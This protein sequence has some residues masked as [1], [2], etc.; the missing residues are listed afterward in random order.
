MQTSTSLLL[1][2][3]LV[4]CVICDTLT[5]VSTIPVR[6]NS[7]T[8]FID[9]SVWYRSN[10]NTLINGNNELAIPAELQPQEF[11]I[12]N[13]TSVAVLFANNA[14]SVPFY[15]TD[16]K[17]EMEKFDQLKDYQDFR[18]IDMRYLDT[19]GKEYIVA[20]IYNTGATVY[21]LIA[22]CL[23][24]KEKVE[25]L[26]NGR[27]PAVRIYQG[28][29]YYLH[30]NYTTGT[31]GYLFKYDPSTGEQSLLQQW[32]YFVS[33]MFLVND[34]IFYHTEEKVL[35]R[36]SITHGT[37]SKTTLDQNA[38]I[39]KAVP[40]GSLT[41]QFLISTN[42]PNTY[43]CPDTLDA[44]KTYSFGAY[45][46][47]A[48]QELWWTVYIPKYTEDKLMTL[49]NKNGEL[50]TLI[51]VLHMN[52][53]SDDHVIQWSNIEYHAPS[54]K[55]L[56]EGAE[57]AKRDASVY[58]PITINLFAYEIATKNWYLVTNLVTNQFTTI[59]SWYFKQD[60]SVALI[61]SV[62]G[63]D[64]LFSLALTGSPVTTSVPETTQ[65]PNALPSYAIPLI[66]G[67]SVGTAVLCATI[68]LIICIVVFCSCRKKKYQ[69][70]L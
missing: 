63:T 39:I 14:T 43:I 54:G 67:L 18:I 6:H 44:C 30:T 25:L 70:V 46:F 68:A 60:G 27:Q 50:E 21:K 2:V 32:N 51:D 40:A 59:S 3:G 9:E 16:G 45:T 19:Q 12:I 5:Q 20:T 36:Y 41:Q 64:Q 26:T 8:A 57:L 1:V 28:A 69:R 29:F 56:F 55:V 66:I 53:T 49:N 38:I 11:R 17:K 58:I 22:I 31:N 48:L 15:R 47:G 37:T 42:G 65:S 7:N 13:A 61:K 23:Q 10:N 35:T 34:G 52:K 62:N 33:S 24:T 4:S